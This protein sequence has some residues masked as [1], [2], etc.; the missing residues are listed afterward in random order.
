[1]S[2]FWLK[3]IKT[4][5]RTFLQINSCKEYFNFC[6]QPL[7]AV[8]KIK[9]V[10]GKKILS[11]LLLIF[12]ISALGIF[13]IGTKETQAGFGFIGDAILNIFSTLVYAFFRFFSL[14]LKISGFFLNWAFGLERFTDV[15]VVQEGWRISRGVVN[16]FF[17]LVLMFIAFAAILQI[18]TYGLKKLLPKLIIAALLINFSLVIAGAIIDFSQV[19]SHFFLKPFEGQAVSLSEFVAK[20]LNIT[21][22]FEAKGGAEAVGAEA[23]R[24]G[25]D[26]LTVLI[27][28]LGGLAV[29]I[30]MFIVMTAAAGFLIVR[31]VA[32]W[33]L[34]VLMPIAWL[35]WILPGLNKQ[36]GNWWS[37]FL[38]WVFFAPAFA[39]FFYLTLMTIGHVNEK[40]EV[41]GGFLS[42]VYSKVPLGQNEEWPDAFFSSSELILQY[43]F[44]ILLLVASIVV[45][46]KAGVYGAGYAMSTVKW[47]G[48]GAAGG[49]SRWLATGAK[50][51]KWMGGGLMTKGVRK[52]GLERAARGLETIGRAKQKAALWTSPGAG[53]RTWPAY[54]K[55]I[56]A[57]AYARPT[58]NL[59]DQLGFVL[60]LGKERTR[61]GEQAEEAEVNRRK[62][63]I[64]DT[65]RA[66][67]FLLDGLQKSA[68]AGNKIDTSAYIRLLFEQNDQNEIIKQTIFGSKEV[69]GEK[70]AGIV[71]DENVTKAVYAAL[72]RAGFS[73]EGAAKIAMDLGNISFASGNYMTFGMGKYDIEKGRFRKTSI[74]EQ[75]EGGIAKA[76]NLEAQQKTRG[77]HWNSLMEEVPRTKENPLGIGRL[78]DGGRELLKGITAGDIEQLNRTRGD[79]QIKAGSETGIEDMRKFADELEATD[80]VQ[81]GLIK[82]FA[83][84]LHLLRTGEIPTSWY[85][86]DKYGELRW[87]PKK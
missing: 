65:G 35:F 46:Q 74:K 24:K 78:H 66:T 32:L 17:V 67:E 80:S 10:R 7:K 39:F 28:I 79:F 41:V 70:Q 20:G 15:G 54:R 75:R 73:E 49:A 56:E 11:T 30:I 60:S 12:T 47:V 64:S 6:I 87:K 22:I 40:G 4:R 38:K 82:R 58:G 81:A 53:R 86:E 18:E 83:A 5:P 13:V 8:K 16:L 14:L 36:W 26:A 48:K 59:R 31:V 57:R 45:A 3:I 76:S 69:L 72:E 71:S 27:G 2:F 68:A 44:L 50:M 62:K 55:E 25:V 43:I 1:M 85:N 63:E 51:P 77:W 37:S 21:K 34:L 33:I 84:Q 23:K 29:I 19:L 52:L 61:F 9:K 42:N